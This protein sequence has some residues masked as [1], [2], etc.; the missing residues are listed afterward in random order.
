MLSI[1]TPTYKDP[2]LQKT[3]NSLLENAEGEVE[4]IV[5]FDGYV[6]DDS[7]LNNKIVPVILEKKTGMRGALNAGFLQAKGEY[8]MKTDSHCLYCP[9]YDKIMTES[10]KDNWLIIPRRYS[11]LEEGEWKRNDGKYYRDYHYFTFPGMRV[12]EWLARNDVRK[13]YDIDDTITFQGSCWVANRKYFMEHVGLL[14]DREETYGSFAQDQ[15]EVGL[16]YWLGGGEVK[17]NKNAWYAHLSRKPRHYAP[18]L[19]PREYKYIKR[20]VNNDK[21]HLW[22]AQHWMN[23]KEPNMIYPFSWLIEKFMPMP[24]WPKE[25]ELWK[26]PH[27]VI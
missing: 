22:T 25:K 5:V 9:G 14:D 3:I 18:G 6:P 21:Y 23:N 19:Y 17:V 12:L 27:S 1:V 20:D 11:L 26:P 24:G 4:V 15:Q 2:F 8:M 10:C 13:D 16:K 7:I